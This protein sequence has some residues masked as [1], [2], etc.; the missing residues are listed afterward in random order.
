MAAA[1]RLCTLAERIIVWPKKLGIQFHYH[2]VIALLHSPVGPAVHMWNILNSIR[3]KTHIGLMVI[4][5]KRPNV[6]I[7]NLFMALTSHYTDASHFDDDKRSGRENGGCLLSRLIWIFS[8]SSVPETNFKE[9]SLCITWLR[10]LRFIG[11]GVARLAVLVDQMQ[12]AISCDSLSAPN[13]AQSSRRQQQVIE[14]E[15]I[16]WV[17]HCI[18]TFD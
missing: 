14:N 16:N 10:E 15:R 12:S 11:G 1:N 8:P 17:T 3:T 4:W 18:L 5:R 9:E 6:L 2:G 13:I 7:A